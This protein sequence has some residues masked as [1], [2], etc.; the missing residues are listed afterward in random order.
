MGAQL[1]G[2]HP[3]T[4]LTETEYSMNK[5]AASRTEADAI[6]NAE[7]RKESAVKLRKE[8]Q[9]T[10]AASGIEL[11]GTAAQVIQEDE[12]NARIEAMNMIYAGKT[13]AAMMRSEARL[14]RAK[15]YTELGIKGGKMMA[16]G[17]A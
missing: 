11:E 10:Y 13:K 9:A 2:M 3:L 1:G 17:G 16:G 12:V 14:N 6:Y 15:A 5:E 7:L 8:Q 4:A